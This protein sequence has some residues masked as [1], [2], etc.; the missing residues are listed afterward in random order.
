MVAIECFDS[1]MLLDPFEEQFN[2]PTVVEEKCNRQ[3][4]EH[5]IVGQED[6]PAIGLGVE[7]TDS[8]ERIGIDSQTPRQFSPYLLLIL[9]SRVVNWGLPTSC[10]DWLESLV[11]QIFH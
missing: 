6:E 8:P 11:Q 9:G 7:I 1:K 3:S 10:H 4:W 2:L 5:K